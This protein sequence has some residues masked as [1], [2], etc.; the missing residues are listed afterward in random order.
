MAFSDPNG[1]KTSRTTGFLFCLF[2][3]EPARGRSRTSA[4]SVADGTYVSVSPWWGRVKGMGPGQAHASRGPS[5]LHNEKFLEPM[6]I[7]ADP[8]RRMDRAGLLA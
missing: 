7:P 2:N 3:A 8:V 1:M 5:R 4:A 6:S